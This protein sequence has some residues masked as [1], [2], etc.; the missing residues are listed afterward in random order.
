MSGEKMRARWTLRLTDET[1]RLVEQASR[2]D[3][4]PIIAW[5]RMVLTREA[6][7]RVRA[8]ERENA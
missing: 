2:L 1:H 6:K 7:R 4:L 3:E 5:I 8:E